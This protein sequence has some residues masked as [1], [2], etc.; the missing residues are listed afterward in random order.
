[1][2]RRFN[3]F[4]CSLLVLTLNFNLSSRA[5]Y[6]FLEYD[7][8]I[9]VFVTDCINLSILGGFVSGRALADMIEFNFPMSNDEFV[10]IFFLLD[11]LLFF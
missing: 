2:L 1:M 7:L 9:S 8:R 3:Y 10:G 11:Y 6:A 5:I 4:F